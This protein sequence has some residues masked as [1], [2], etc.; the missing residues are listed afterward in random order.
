MKLLFRIIF[1]FL[2]FFLSFVVGAQEISSKY[3]VSTKGIKIGE[4]V[5]NLKQEN[6]LYENRILLKN[7]GILSAIYKFNGDYLSVGKIENGIFVSQSYSHKWITK[8]KKKEVKIIFKNNK[9]NTIKQTPFEDEFARIDLFSLVDYSDP[10]TSF[11]NILNNSQS[12]NTVDGRRVYT[13]KVDEDLKRPE[14][15]TI[16][17]KN[18]TN[19]WADHKRNDLEKIVFLKSNELTLPESIEVYFKGSVFMVYKN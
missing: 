12:S 2:L 14:M 1:F 8:K 17:I 18:Y 10:L 9:I 3:S 5:W 4:L 7:K 11:I 15:K 19:I 13:M 16:S 6:N